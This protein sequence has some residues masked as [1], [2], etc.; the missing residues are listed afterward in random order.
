ML[1]S[2]AVSFLAPVEDVEREFQATY[3][4]W[5]NTRSGKIMRRSVSAQM[6]EALAAHVDFF[7][8]VTELPPTFSA[9]GV[10]PSAADSSLTDT[11]VTPDVIFEA[12]NVY[13]HSTDHSTTMAVFEA[14]GQAY[15]PSD[16]ATFEETFNVPGNKVVQVIGPNK[17]YECASNPNDCTEANLDVQVSSCARRACAL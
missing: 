15:S 10:R 7:A 9:H 4:R 3:Y 5:R 11:K 16:L 8:H 1:S 6:P 2:V 13:P 14:L 12:Y 17:D